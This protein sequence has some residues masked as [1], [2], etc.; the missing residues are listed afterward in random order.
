VCANPTP[1]AAEQC[2]MAAGTVGAA[3][4]LEPTSKNKPPWC[5]H[6]FEL[7]QLGSDG[8]HVGLVYVRECYG[9]PVGAEIGSEAKALLDGPASRVVTPNPKS[10]ARDAQRKRKSGK[11]VEEAVNHIAMVAKFLGCSASIVVDPDLIEVETKGTS[12]P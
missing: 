1:I 11:D 2:Q 12:M 10:D 7:S 6:R 9:A 3:T 4:R 5:C 8:E